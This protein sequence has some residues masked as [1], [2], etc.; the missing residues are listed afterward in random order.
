MELFFAIK[1][2]FS[3]KVKIEKQFDYP[4][5]DD[6]GPKPG[7]SNATQF[8]NRLKGVID[9]TYQEHNQ[10]NSNKNQNSGG[11]GIGNKEVTGFLNTCLNKM[12]VDYKVS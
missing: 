6:I 7:Y 5:F 3:K 1:T 4:D 11:L 12:G 10:T 8:D 9:N 2:Y